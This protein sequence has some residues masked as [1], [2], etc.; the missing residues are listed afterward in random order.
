MEL[1]RRY[2]N[3]AF[4]ILKLVLISLI[5]SPLTWLIM[6]TWLRDFAYRINI[7]WWVLLS[8]EQQL[9]IA[10]LTV[11]FQAISCADK[12]GEEFENGISEQIC[13]WDEWD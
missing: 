8:P 3:H 10:L 7:S 9:L 11:S 13:C 4:K 12:S 2:C 5:A 1:R 6:N